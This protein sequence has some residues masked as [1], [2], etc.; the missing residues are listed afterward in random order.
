MRRL[1]VCALLCVLLAG[2]A[3]ASATTPPKATSAT[4]V[5]PH[6]IWHPAPGLTW[7]WQLQGTVDTSVSAQVYDIDLW[8]ESS[9]DA[10]K[11]LVTSL[12]AKGRKVICYVDVGSFEN[13]RPDFSSFPQSVLGKQYVNYPDER[14][15]DI[16]QLDVIGPIMGKRMDMCAAAGFD[17]ISSTNSC[18]EDS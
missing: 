1:S 9:A 2:C 6:A 15:L 5:G 14:W 7:Q 17:G 13:W 3:S 16:R 12:H 11:S 8:T 18:H 10:V 4:P